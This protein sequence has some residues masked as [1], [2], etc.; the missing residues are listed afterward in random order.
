MF[1]ELENRLKELKKIAVAFSG[2]IDS[3]FLL[4]TANKVL[5]RENVLAIIGN[6]QMIPRKDYK[7][8]IEFLNENNFQ[9]KEIPV[10]CLEVLEF[11][12]NHEDRCYHCKK[13]IMTMVKKVAK[14]NG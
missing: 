1:E 11:K 14:E 4:F 7:E 8:A 12:E 5:G 9:Y 2:G 10:D 6:G 13:S 3:S